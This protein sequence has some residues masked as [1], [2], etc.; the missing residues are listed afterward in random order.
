MRAFRLSPLL[1]FPKPICRPLLLFVADN[2]L[3]LVVSQYHYI[4]LGCDLAEGTSI[5]ITNFGVTYYSNGRQYT[6]S[7]F[8]QS[9][10][11]RVLPSAGIALS[12]SPRFRRNLSV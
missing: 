12:G 7:I 4:A 10:I 6:R 9:N 1:S 11:V 3:T 2:S 8:K 5:F